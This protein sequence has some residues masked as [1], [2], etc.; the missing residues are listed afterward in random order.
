MD[1]V[2]AN[3]EKT[4][5]QVGEVG[6]RNGPT[7]KVAMRA[8]RIVANLSQTS[9]TQDLVVVRSRTLWAGLRALHCLMIVRASKPGTWF[10]PDGVE[11][12]M[13][14]WLSKASYA[15]KDAGQKR[16]DWV[17]IY[18]NG[19]P[20]FSTKK[21][22][23]GDRI[24]R[25]VKSRSI[26]SEIMQAFA[27]GYFQASERRDISV[28]HDSFPALVVDAT[29]GSTDLKAVIHNRRQKDEGQLLMTFPKLSAQGGLLM[30]LDLVSDF[31][32]LNDRIEELGAIRRNYIEGGDTEYAV[33]RAVEHV[34]YMHLKRL[35]DSV[36]SAVETLGVSVHPKMPQFDLPERPE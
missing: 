12:W 13:N 18:R 10:L 30:S 17:A 16:R 33:Q 27:M 9:G 3:R 19:A 31:L 21:D 20:V 23:A 2:V 34:P 4:I 25:L 35:K 36:L 29:S 26:D 14:D 32:E 8:N 1:L 6:V 24:E 7:K 5:F 28:I 11:E 22:E 15:A